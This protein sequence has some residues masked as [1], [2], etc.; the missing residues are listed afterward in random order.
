MSHYDAELYALVHT[1]TPGDVEHYLRLARGGS[2]ILELGSGSG[3]V[4]LPLAQAGYEVTGLELDEGMLALARERAARTA[5]RVQKR[6]TLVAGDMARFELGARFDRIFAPFGSLYSLLDEHDL[7]SCL[8]SVRAHLEPGGIFA[9]DGYAADD[10]HAHAHPTDYPTDLLEPTAEIVHRRRRIRVLEK[11]SWDRARQRVD[12]TY[13]Y[14]D[15]DGEL[16][17]EVT[18]R[19]RYLLSG[20]IEKLLQDA[21]LTLSA[22]YG[23][24][25]GAPFERATSRS[26]VVVAQG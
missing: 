1:G 2:R 24:F 22:M 13:V 16:V 20:Q 23:D 21:G 7:M 18:I 15:R 6:I 8:R 14:L 5:M 26:L 11:S 19:Q 17:H 3:R 4:L 25:G 9:F 12:A 10:F